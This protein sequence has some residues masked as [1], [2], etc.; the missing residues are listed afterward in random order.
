MTMDAEAQAGWDEWVKAHIRN[1][2][3][4]ERRAVRQEMKDYVAAWVDVIADA[5]G[6]ITGGLERHI[7]AEIKRLDETTRG[8]NITGTY[9]AG[10]TY[11]RLDV[12]TLNSSW[13]IARRD[14]PGL[15]PGDGWQVGPVGKKGP[16]GDPADSA[17]LKR[18][19]K[20]V[21]ELRSEIG[22]LRAMWSRSN[23]A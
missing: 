1:A 2:L 14:D 15:C 18:L 9:D 20:E 10:K 4:K 12:A 22:L 13:F 5:S 11:K 7:N 21:D 19:R 17:E 3:A 6:E 8:F 23:A 16:K